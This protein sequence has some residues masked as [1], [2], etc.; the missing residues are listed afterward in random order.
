[1]DPP[2]AVLSVGVKLNH[3]RRP[4]GTGITA[5]L[6]VPTL[7]VPSSAPWRGGAAGA[8]FSLSL[9]SAAVSPA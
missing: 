4:S 5:V 6:P 3:V 8:R 1:M 7:N 9:A 2:D